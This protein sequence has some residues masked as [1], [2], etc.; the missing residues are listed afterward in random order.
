MTLVVTS[1]RV[2]LPLTTNRL[3]NRRM[4]HCTWLQRLMSSRTDVTISAAVHG[5][6]TTRFFALSR[7]R[8]ARDRPGSSAPARIWR[9]RTILLRAIPLAHPSPLAEQASPTAFSSRHPSTTTHLARCTGVRIESVPLRWQEQSPPSLHG[10]GA[11][12]SDSSTGQHRY[13]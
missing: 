11:V 6:G 8:R 3:N 7:P 13:S 5:F 10:W 9:S 12:V 4:V 1:R 2:P